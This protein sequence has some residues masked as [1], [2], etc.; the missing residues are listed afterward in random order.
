MRRAL[1]SLAIAAALASPAAAEVDPACYVAASARYGPAPELLE[2]I[3][4]VESGRVADRVG[5]AGWGEDL[6]AMQVHSQHLPK[7][8]QWGVTR[9]RLLSEPCTCVAI[10]AWI[11]AGEVAAVGPGWRAVARYH[12]GPKYETDLA[13]RRRGIAYAWRVHHALS[14]LQGAR[15]RSGSR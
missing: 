9:E 1:A 2:A 5:T 7:L 4:E 3:A 14:A 13:V 8:A 6:C 10:G 15:A 12:T 11:L